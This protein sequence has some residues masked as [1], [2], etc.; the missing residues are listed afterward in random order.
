VRQGRKATGFQP[1]EIAGLPCNKVVRFFVFL[2]NKFSEFNMKEIKS[3]KDAIYDVKRG[4]LIVGLTGYTGSGCTT[5]SRILKRSNEPQI[6]SCESIFGQSPKLREQRIYKKLKRFWENSDFDWKPF[7][8]IEVAKVIFAFAVYRA[9]NSKINNLHLKQIRE[10]IKG[11]EKSLAA[12]KHLIK[13]RKDYKRKAS[14]LIEAYKICGNLYLTFK[15]T[16]SSSLG[17]FIELMQNYGDEIRKV[18]QVS[19][20]RKKPS[21]KNLFVLPE[22][23]RRLIKAYQES[24]SK[25]FVIDAFRNP[26]E[27]E[28]FKRR[29]SEFYCVGILRELKERDEA[30]REE[31]SDNSLSKIKKR[32][33]GKGKNEQEIKRTKDNISE[34]VTS[35]NINA[36]LQKADVFIKNQ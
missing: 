22:A 3:Y 36:C 11:E 20:Y 9:L 25:H 2:D 21:P 4:F 5:V 1:F 15:N 32:E 14:E 31:V 10:L 33:E 13:N 23:I 17:D 27:V 12:L 34:W 8:H 28:Y 6:P 7:V 18:G 35:Q 26:Y 19:P 24:G 29:Y 16:V 30:L